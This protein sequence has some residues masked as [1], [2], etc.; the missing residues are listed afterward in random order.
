MNRVFNFFSTDIYYFNFEYTSEKL[1]ILNLPYSNNPQ[2]GILIR[3]LS[4][5]KNTYISLISFIQKDKIQIQ[6]N[7]DIFFAN[8]KNEELAM[9]YLNN[10]SKSSFLAG[11]NKL[12]KNDF[13]YLKIYLLAILLIPVVFL[14][15]LFCKNIYQNKSYQYVFDGFCISYS[16]QVILP[17]WLNSIKPK[18]MFFSNHLS[19]FNRCLIKIAFEKN[20]DTIFLQH[21]S[22]NVNYPPLDYFKIIF[23]EGLD[24]YIK[25]KNSGTV[26]SNIYLVGMSK[27]DEYNNNINKR[28]SVKS[29]AICT[30]GLDSLEE[31]EK[32]INLMTQLN[33]IKIYLRP[34]PSD[35]RFISWM[36]LAKR[37]NI[38]FSDV[39]NEISFEFLKNIDVLISGDS[40]IHLE[41][42]LFN[43]YSLY[44][45]TNNTNLDWYG[46]HE[47]N[48]IPYYSDTEKLYNEL[49]IL[50]NNKI[51][52]RYKAKTYCETVDTPYDGNSNF[53][54]TSVLNDS[55]VD[56]IFF[57]NMDGNQ[58]LIFSL[59]NYVL[60]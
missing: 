23:L 9:K 11:H 49:C 45:D 30:N 46:F 7:S 55:K 21:A 25:Y 40:N 29:I 24:S 15:K 31:I 12:F 51:N 2:K 4:L 48:L 10:I 59:T 27:F 52:V 58:N 33:Y 5:F 16:C 43:I 34:H 42:T 6:T 3:I 26:N 32:L 20:I 28:E 60:N 35:R 36:N 37:Y 13:P 41:A 54:I 14:R 38:Y 17:L 18:R 39:H 50:I 57:K 53:L 47:N 8:S 56:S 1:G 22:I 19:V 44:F